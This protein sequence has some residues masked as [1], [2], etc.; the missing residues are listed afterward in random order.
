MY[1]PKWIIF[2]T[3]IQYIFLIFDVKFY[4]IYLNITVVM[5]FNICQNYQFIIL[6]FG[7]N[8]TCF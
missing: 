8:N 6:L 2:Y 3:H 1:E 5:F 4:I 7:F